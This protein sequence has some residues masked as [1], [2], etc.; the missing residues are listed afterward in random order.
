MLM[1]VQLQFGQWNHA[2][3]AENLSPL[4]ALQVR[5]SQN[6]APLGSGPTSAALEEWCKEKSLRFSCFKEGHNVAHALQP[7]HVVI[8]S[9]ELPEHQWKL[10]SML[11]KCSPSG[12]LTRA[13][14]ERDSKQMTDFPPELHKFGGRSIVITGFCKRNGKIV[15]KSKSSWGEELASK[16]W[17]LPH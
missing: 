7:E 8:A 10:L 14:F 12:A 2:L 4:T 17:L 5:S 13:D 15:C 3:Q 1:L 6:M 16:Q 9:F 11:F